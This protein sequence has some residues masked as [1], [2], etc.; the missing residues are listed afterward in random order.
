ME[1]TKATSVAYF[2]IEDI[3]ACEAAM[4]IVMHPKV[5]NLVEEY[6]KEIPFQLDYVGAWRSFADADFSANQQF[7]HRDIDTLQSL[8]VFCYLTDVEDGSGPHVFVPDSLSTDK[9]RKKGKQFSDAVV[10]QFYPV[11]N[12]IVVKGKRGTVFVANTIALHKGLKPVEKDRILLQFIFSVRRTPF[13]RP[14]YI[15]SKYNFPNNYIFKNFT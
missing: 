12:Q 13:L 5:M 9:F 1:K 14:K 6:F 11:E 10:N 7:F 2:R 15:K 4:K 8:K 3:V